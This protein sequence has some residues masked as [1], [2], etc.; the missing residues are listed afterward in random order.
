MLSQQTPKPNSQRV[1][2]IKTHKL[3]NETRTHRKILH[4]ISMCLKRAPKKA[5]F[6]AFSMVTIESKGAPKT[7]DIV[8]K[9]GRRAGLEGGRV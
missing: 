2:S 4:L 6:F 5:R 8:A 1:K 9:G 7:L 3:N